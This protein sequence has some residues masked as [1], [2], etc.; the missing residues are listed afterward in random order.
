MTL[1][2]K[3]AD[4]SNMQHRPIT[5]AW[6]CTRGAGMLLPSPPHLYS[7]FF[8]AAR[9]AMYCCLSR[10]LDGSSMDRASSTRDLSLMAGA[11]VHS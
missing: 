11:N 4:Y 8:S 9:A 10:K 6:Q 2:T 3:H 1:L 5:A 7:A